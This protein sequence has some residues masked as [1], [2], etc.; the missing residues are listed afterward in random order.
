M[1]SELRGVVTNLNAA[2]KNVQNG[3]IR[4]PEITGAVVDEAKD[5]PGLVQQTAWRGKR[6]PRSGCYI[7][8]ESEPWKPPCRFSG[9]TP[10]CTVGDIPTSIRVGAHRNVP[11]NDKCRNRDWIG[12][13]IRARPGRSVGVT[14]HSADFGDSISHD[15]RAPL[16]EM[17]GF[18]Q[19]LLDDYSGKLDERGVSHLQKIMRSA[20]RLDHL[21]QDVLSYSKVLHAKG[22]MGPVDPREWPLA[23]L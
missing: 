9:K 14:D 23:G 6:N 19:C 7:S 1:M 12:G 15:T 22:V 5:L 8:R 18:A 10:P 16:R 3:T 11:R 17:Q 21:I 4:L 20:L 13:E 2:V